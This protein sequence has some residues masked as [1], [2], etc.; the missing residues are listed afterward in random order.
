MT[1]EKELAIVIRQN[2]E[3]SDRP[4]LRILADATGK[5]VEEEQI[6]DLV[7]VHHVF[8]EKVME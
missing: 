2:K 5:K 8:I 1:N 6:K 7:K 4:V 3:F